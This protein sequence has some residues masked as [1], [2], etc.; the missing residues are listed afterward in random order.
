MK[1]PL[2][3]IVQI[4]SESKGRSL[5]M[6]L[7]LIFAISFTH[8]SSAQIIK[9]AGELLLPNKAQTSTDS[10][11]GS[12]YRILSPEERIKSDSIK[13]LEMTMQI[14]EMKLNEILLRNK[15][16]ENNQLHMADSLK[17]AEQ[18]HRIDSLRAV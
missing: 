2:N 17:R 14:E 11:N 16:D 15:L 18:I 8:T 4:L 1:Y 12:D 5:I 6:S 9:K 7:I 13:L 10:V 3:K